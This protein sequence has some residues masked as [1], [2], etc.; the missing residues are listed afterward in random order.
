MKAQR[1]TLSIAFAFLLITSVFLPFDNFARAQGLSA[2]TVTG[3]VVD[4]NKAVVSSATVTLENALT[5]YNRSMTTGADGA[6]RFD[7]V[8]FNN[9]VYTASATGFAGIRGAINIRTSVPITLTISLALGTATASVTVTSTGADLLENVPSAHVDV[10]KSLINRLPAGDP[11]SGLSTVVTLSAP[12]VAA[13]SNGGFHPE[14]DHFQAQ[15]VVDGTPITDQQSKLF[16]TQIPVNAIESVEVV[17]GAAAAEYG[18]KTS[19]VINSTTRSG[20]NK[21]KATGSFNGSYGT[22]GTTHEDGAIA[23]GNAKAGNFVA[24]NYERS[25]RFL[26]TPEFTV[27]HAHGTAV[28]LFDRIDYSPTTKDTFHLN[29]FLA[30]NRFQTPNQFDQQAVSQDQRQLVHTL[31]IA[32]GYVH[33]F[34]PN[35]VLTINPYY[36]L[37]TVQYH[38]S[39]DSFSDQ[40]ITFNQSRRLNNIGVKADLSYVKGKNNAKFGVQIQDTLLT[41]GFQFGI[42]DPAFN[43]PESEGFLPGLLPFDLT[44]GGSPFGFHGHTNIKQQ[45]FYGQD[46]ITLGN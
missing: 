7:N 15:I 4:P 27:L 3:I 17:T 29:L 44:R 30:R 24:F 31:N 41:E 18:D 45:A 19:L 11:G 43:D 16:S 32:P 22:F 2:G 8:P 46:S 35:T 23:Y 38:A 26:D 28:N 39:P 12:G 42:T 25:N 36:R 14:G 10:D 33:V 5:G 13:D 1:K 40:P 20:L 34:N 6:F 37:D 21:T 9:Y